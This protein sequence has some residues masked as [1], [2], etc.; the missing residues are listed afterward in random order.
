MKPLILNKT[1][2][3]RHWIT[4]FTCVYRASPVLSSQFAFILHCYYTSLKSPKALRILNLFSILIFL[5]GPCCGI[6]WT[7]KYFESFVVKL[8]EFSHGGC[9]QLYLALSNCNFITDIQK[10]GMQ[11]K[12]A[13]STADLLPRRLRKS[14]SVTNSGNYICLLFTHILLSI[15]LASGCFSCF[16][17][18]M[19]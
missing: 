10:W 12:Q 4:V 14:T 16:P 17:T 11:Y 1:M 13:F 2:H 5:S 6:I 19:D 8:S 7:Q 3:F 18:D 15:P 9:F